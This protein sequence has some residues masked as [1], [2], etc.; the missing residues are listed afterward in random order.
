MSEVAIAGIE[1]ITVLS[2]GLLGGSILHSLRAKGYQGEL[3]VWARNP[4]RLTQIT[5]LNLGVKTFSDIKLSVQNADLVILCSPVEVMESLAQQIAQDLKPGC[6]VTD[7]GSV[8]API[9]DAM[10]RVLP[11]HVHFAGSHPM[12]GSE[13]TGLQHAQKD[14]FPNA[15]CILTPTTEKRGPEFTKVAEFWQLLGC[16]IEYLSPQEHDLVIGSVSHLP[17]LAAALLVNLA[18]NEVQEPERFCGN[19]FRDTTRIAS[20][21]PELWNGIFFSNRSAML[22]LISKL[23]ALLA[24]TRTFLQENDEVGLTN[25]LTKAKKHRDQL[26]T[27]NRADQAP[28]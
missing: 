28:S 16:H 21:S 6:I 10:A 8:K 18:S 3:R 17:H 1:S 7:V 23:E 12:A 24:E 5:A 13:K 4:E 26:V 14:L 20:G 2:P 9:V 11:A 19:G 15:T 22:T 25:M 27:F